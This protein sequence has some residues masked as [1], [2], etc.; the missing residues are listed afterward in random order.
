[1]SFIGFW[2][3]VELLV[4]LESVA[5]ASSRHPF[6]DEVDDW[7]DSVS[8]SQQQIT[9]RELE[10]QQ[11]GP[12]SAKLQASKDD[13]V[14][15]VDYRNTLNLSF[16]YCPVKSRLEGLM[17]SSVVRLT[18]RKYML[19]LMSRI[20][21]DYESKQEARIEERKYAELMRTKKLILYRFIPVQEAPP[22]IC[23]Y[24]LFKLYLYCEDV[25][26]QRLKK[27]LPK[28]AKIPKSLYKLLY[29]EKPTEVA[30]EVDEEVPMKE[31]LVNGEPTMVPMKPDE[32]EAMRKEQELAKEIEE[33]YMFT[34]EEYDSLHYETDAV[35]K[36]REAKTINE[37]YDRANNIV[38]ALF[39][40]MQSPSRH[41]K[42]ADGEAV[43]T[44]TRA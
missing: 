6:D 16:S 33:G 42:T 14:A 15:S 21:Q 9:S 17:N 40:L 34:K 3:T 38:G 1:M 24:P 26:A 37:M 22:E 23:E 41:L 5:Q 8:K 35:K 7:L 36:L 30:D 13:D 39:S 29:P 12:P 20:R 44:K 4:A 25:I 43:S 10:L 28:K 31:I 2:A 27:R 32:I 11:Q 19:K 18:D